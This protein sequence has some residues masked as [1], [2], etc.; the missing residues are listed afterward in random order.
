MIGFSTPEIEQVAV[1]AFLQWPDTFDVLQGR[2]IGPEHFT[3]ANRVIFAQ[4]ISMWAERTP[5]DLV[6]LTETLRSSG[7]LQLAG[8]PAYVTETYLAAGGPNSLGYHLDILEG[9][10]RKIQLQK[11]CFETIEN[12]TSG[13]DATELTQTLLDQLTQG[14]F[15]S[16]EVPCSFAEAISAKMLRMESSDT[17]TDVL[18]TGI[19][20]LDELSPLRHGDMPLIA[21]S[22]KA[23]KSILALSIAL[24][25]ARQGV[26]VLVFSLED[27]GPKAIDRLFAGHSRIPSDRHHL[28]AMS[29]DEQTK[30]SQSLA[31]LAALPIHIR[32]DVF[33]L[34]LILSTAKELRAR[35]NIGLVIVDYGQLIRVTV[36]K[37]AN[38]EQEVAKMSRDLRLLAME[39]NVPVIVLSQ[40]N[41]DGYTRESR[42]L[43]QDAT[44]M[45]ELGLDEDDDLRGKRWIKIPWQ[46][47][48]QSGVQFPVTFLG[49]IAR[50]E[51][52][53]E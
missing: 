18:R 35:E 53:T 13:G 25:V 32:D 24:N 21:G 28:S 36:N 46:R 12:L 45:W 19:A 40:L 33:D 6:G 52:Y 50:V 5:I 3:G 26:P 17:A 16:R 48:G 37:G 49:S 27:R 31:E 41:A 43:E 23:G 22:R 8:G 14:S 47:N 30:A 15:Q 4:A 10:Q 39:M 20:R 34:P 29:Y 42:S 9:N 38:R 7:L 2:R 44:A 51:N 11:I 1:S